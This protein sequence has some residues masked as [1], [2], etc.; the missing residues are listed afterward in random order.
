MSLHLDW[1]GHD[2]A[3]Y[4]VEHW[5]YSKVLPCGKLNGVGVWE[6]E[7]YIGCILFSYGANNNMAQEY[8]L[9]QT[10]CVEL[11]RVALSTHK[12]PVTKLIKVALKFL[13]KKNPNLKLVV[14]YADANKGHFGGIYQG[15]NWV[16]VGQTAPD[17]GQ[18]INGE[19]MH[20]RTV[21]SRFGTNSTVELRKRGIVADFVKCLPKFKY[22]YPLT[23]DM[24]LKIEPLRKPYPKKSAL[25]VHP[26]RTSGDQPGEGGSIPTPTHRETKQVSE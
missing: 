22:L 8:G 4:A 20:R 25:V 1:V 23:D 26:V 13:L 7:K 19:V 6:D 9:S 15:G 5:H 3:K 12:T 10:E 2:A 21:F 16:Y 24:R 18:L 11:T 17:G 14:S